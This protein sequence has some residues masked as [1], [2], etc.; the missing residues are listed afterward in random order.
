MEA[1]G[2]GTPALAKKISSRFHVATARCTSVSLS[3]AREDVGAHGQRLAALF[4]DGRRRRPRARLVDVGHDH[5]RAL[6]GH[7]ERGG[8]TDPG[9]AAC[10]H[11][12]PVTKPH[13]RSA[14]GSTITGCSLRRR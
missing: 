14:A 12:H 5:P 13:R 8:R 7:G 6:A 11:R 3:V 1:C 10:H 9:A 4:L 2:C